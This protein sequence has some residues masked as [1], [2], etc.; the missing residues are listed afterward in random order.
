MKVSTQSAGS[1]DS[2]HD[3]ISAV[4]LSDGTVQL[5]STVINKIRE[6][7]SYWTFGGGEVAD[8][9]VRD[10]PDCGSSD[11]ITTLPDSTTNNNLL[12]LPRI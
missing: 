2:R 7:V 6:G 1:G 10:C 3:H 9:V 12:E 5:R 11:Y 4:E 8:V